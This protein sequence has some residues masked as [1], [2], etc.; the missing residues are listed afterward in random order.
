MSRMY[1]TQ[2]IYS[3]VKHTGDSTKHESIS[4]KALKVVFFLLFFVAGKFRA[5]KKR[6]NDELIR[7]ITKSL[8]CLWQRFNCYTSA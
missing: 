5:K 4:F 7:S 8:N 1:I 6:K 3:F 2:S